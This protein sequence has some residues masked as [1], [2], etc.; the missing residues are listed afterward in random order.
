M[1]NTITI[2]AGYLLSLLSTIVAE[3]IAPGN[4]DRIRLYGHGNENHGFSEEQY[5]HIKNNYWLMTIEKTHGQSIYGKGHTEIG[6]SAAAERIAADKPDGQVLFYWNAIYTWSEL[7]ETVPVALA[8]NPTWARINS[9]GREL[10]AWPD[11]ASEDWWVNNA[12]N[13]VNSSAHTGVFVD[14]GRR[15]PDQ[16][17]RLRDT[18]DGL[19]IYNGFGSVSDG[20]LVGPEVLDNADGFFCEQF[21]SRN[22]STP[23]AAI[24]LMD[25]C[26]AVPADKFIV[27]QGNDGET[28]ND[29]DYTFPL[30]CFLI[31]A[32]DYSFYMY[33]D[34]SATRLTHWDPEYGYRLG[35]PKG[36]AKKENNVYTRSFEYCD[37][38]VDLNTVTS[39]I[40][41]HPA[42]TR[43]IAHWSLNEAEGSQIADLSGYENNASMDSCTWVT[44]GIHGSALHFKGIDSS[45]AITVPASSFDRVDDQITVSL[46]QWGT[47]T[48]PDRSSALFAVNASGERVLNI[49]LPWN[50]SK[51][52][53]DAG[54]NETGFDRISK[55]AS[56]SEYSSGWHNWVFTKNANTGIMEI[57]HDGVL[58]HSGSDL[59]K[60]M[61]GITNA[62]IGA[63]TS[64]YSY[65]GNIDDVKIFNVA[66]DSEE[67]ASMYS[68]TLDHLQAYL[69]LNSV[70]SLTSATADLSGRSNNA[71]VSNVSIVE[72]VEDKALNFNG[73][74]SSVTLPG[75]VFVDVDNEIS[76]AMWIN[77]DAVMQP[78][79]D[80]VFHA[81]NADGD[82][83]LNI[84]LPWSNSK[85][86]WDAGNNE[87]YDRVSKAANSSEFAGQWNHWVFTKNT[88]TGTMKI[89]LN[90]TLWTSS[91]GKIKTMSGITEGRLGGAIGQ[92]H[93]AGKMDEVLVF[94]RELTPE[95][96]TTLYSSNE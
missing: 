25:A 73:T 92:Y 67:I 59:E 14:G 87:G 5:E 77:G 11:T 83:V 48:T 66:L 50:N 60:E 91:T 17:S 28:I 56:I 34:H 16:V 38:T 43:P 30:A 35:K 8:E 86:Y 31:I 19:V 68:N 39:S 36:T 64:S 74:N 81:V 44:P 79:A 27:C 95:E 85:V 21:F 10:W 53:W 41:W 61:T 37:V 52:Y 3:P 24:A 94:S 20:S 54:R 89:Y 88:S 15:A 32:N 84:H 6:S 78:Q 13:I 93:Y 62:T 23:E 40:T 12:V 82:R 70:D 57:Y 42:E 33:Q 7:Y 46:W 96:I 1:K 63:Q 22:T 71:S 65:N 26:L 55:T 72:G 58:W 49:H 2:T 9:S 80:S 51:V 47:T 76:I 4:W 18:L 90:G 29:L 75:N 69:A 45:S